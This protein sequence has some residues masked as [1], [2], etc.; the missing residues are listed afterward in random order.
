MG[1]VMQPDMHVIEALSY[2]PSA[3]KGPPEGGP[4]Q[5]N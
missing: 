2:A 5:V 1:Y 4:M 3:S